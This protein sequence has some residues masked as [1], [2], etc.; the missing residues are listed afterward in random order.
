MEHKNMREVEMTL[1]ILGHGYISS[2]P[3]TGIELVDF[4]IQI[5]HF[6]HFLSSEQNFNAS[7]ASIK[8]QV[9]AIVK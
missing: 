5:N 3:L 4:I 8:D 6:S 9:V 1:V 7:F 2:N